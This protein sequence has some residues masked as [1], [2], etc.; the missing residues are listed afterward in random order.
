MIFFVFQAAEASAPSEMGGSGTTGHPAIPEEDDDDED[1]DEAGVEAKVLP[2]LH[3]C[4][5]KRCISL[6][7]IC[8]YFV[9]LGNYWVRF[10]FK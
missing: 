4:L 10:F 3:I 6:K 2:L 9:C 1:V 8:V 7:N 5:G